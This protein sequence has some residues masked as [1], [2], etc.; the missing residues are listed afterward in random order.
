MQIRPERESPSADGDAAGDRVGV[1]P[2]QGSGPQAPPGRASPVCYAEQAD[3]VYMGYLGRDELVAALDELLEAERAGARVA[4]ETA[5]QLQ[6]PGERALME[7]IRRD[8]VKWCG[9]LIAAIQ[10]LDAKPSART[11][12]FHAKAMAIAS[13]PER[14]AFLNRG[15][16]WVVK[17]L[18]ALVPRVREPGIQDELLA[19]L[20][21]H[22]ENIERVA[23]RLAAPEGG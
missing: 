23:T 15:Q 8:E 3:A 9:M 17:K 4:E 16:G 11:G 13:L 19:M 10:S 5:A 18:Q 21:S 6:D 12:A 22:R 2:A 14:M 20:S 1:A 7:A